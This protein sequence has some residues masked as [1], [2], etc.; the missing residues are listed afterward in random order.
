MSVA[1]LLLK[2][3]SE[4]LLDFVEVREKRDRH[5]DNDRSLAVADFELS[6]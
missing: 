5:K 2:L 6:C 1:E 4:S 3:S